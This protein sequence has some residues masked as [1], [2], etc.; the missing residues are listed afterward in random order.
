LKGENPFLTGSFGTAPVVAARECH[1]DE[2]DA[3][4]DGSYASSDE[5]DAF[6]DVGFAGRNPFEV[7]SDGALV[8]S[9]RRQA[10]KKGR[11]PGNPNAGLAR[12]P[13]A[14]RLANLA[15]QLGNDLMCPCNEGSV[16]QYQSRYVSLVH[17][18]DQYDVA[19]LAFFSSQSSFPC[20]YSEGI[21]VALTTRPLAQRSLDQFDLFSIGI[22]RW[23]SCLFGPCSCM[24]GRKC[25]VLLL[26]EA[27]DG[28]P[29]TMK[30]AA[31]EMRRQP[32]KKQRCFAD[33]KQAGLHKGTRHFRVLG[34]E[35]CLST[36]AWLYGY[37][38]FFLDNNS[39]PHPRSFGVHAHVAVNW[40][41]QRP[42]SL[43]RVQ[44]L[45]C[46]VPTIL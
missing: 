42:F 18:Y 33:N 30:E 8:V 44:H 14:V 24:N 5:F 41:Q 10:G 4:S 15:A 6:D 17:Q 3:S 29:D 22:L 21:V 36:F 31:R 40:T 7:P 43:V 16:T 1:H 12:V 2:H 39:T 25:R 13:D 38:I 28:D 20:C 34:L 27:F 32:N 23:L 11:K 46:G 9:G 37:V 35:I 45:L 26:T 19:T